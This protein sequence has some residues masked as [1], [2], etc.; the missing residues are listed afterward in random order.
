MLNHAVYCLFAIILSLA[1]CVGTETHI[2]G[3]ACS[4][5]AAPILAPKPITEAPTT[6]PKPVTPPKAPK[7]KKTM[8]LEISGYS[9]TKDQTDDTPCIAAHRIDICSRKAAGEKLCATN[10]VPIGTTLA[11]D[12]LGTCTVADH[13]AKRMDHHVDWYFTSRKAAKQFGRKNR[14][15]TVVTR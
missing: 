7:L 10:V 9:S 14:T 2:Q 1:G 5:P 3:R 8:I 11:I 12:G 15:V 13:M 4:V 6:K